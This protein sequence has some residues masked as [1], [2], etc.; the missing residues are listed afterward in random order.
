V[1]LA[2]DSLAAGKEVVLS[3]GELVEIGGSFRIP[4][5]LGASRAR[6]REVGTTNRTHP[7][8]YLEA[9]GPQT[10]MILKVHRSNFEIRG[11]TREVDLP[12]LGEIARSRGLPLVEDR[13][14]GTFLDLR[15]YGIPEREAH[16]GLREGADLVLFS[17]DKL[18]GGPQS[19]IVLGRRDLVERMRRNPLARAVR[20]D[21]LTLAALHVTLQ[22]LLDGRALEELPALRMILKKD[23]ELRSAA[24][25]LASGLRAAGFGK[26][27]VER[28]PSLVGGGAMPDVELSGVGVRVEIEGSVEEIARRLRLA[29][30]P[31]M[32]RIQKGALLLDPRTLEEAEIEEV[33]RAFRSLRTVQSR[34]PAAGSR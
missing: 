19:G 34:A 8:D 5:I 21:K 1:L 25:R 11:F 17:G 18:L 24:E 7:R 20:V 4:E 12:E 13:G 30:L 15:P 31:V 33:V 32:A 14:S 26:V 6:L 23:P 28:L 3:R 9:I 29:A 27:H 10:G 22:C 2:V 16:A